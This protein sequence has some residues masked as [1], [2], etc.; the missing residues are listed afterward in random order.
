MKTTFLDL[1]VGGSASNSV[2]IAKLFETEEIASLYFVSLMVAVLHCRTINGGK[3]SGSGE[4]KFR[5]IAMVGR[6]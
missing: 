4:L 5:W 3:K 6:E 1:L 2:T